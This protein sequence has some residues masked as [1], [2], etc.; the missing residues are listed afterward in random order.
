MISFK[1]IRSG[2]TLPEA[3]FYTTDFVFA[4]NMETSP[5][6][7]PSLQSSSP[8]LRMNLSLAK[9]NYAASLSVCE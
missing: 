8:F 1:G 7:Y 2:F 4:D 3:L 6:G 9:M 5:T